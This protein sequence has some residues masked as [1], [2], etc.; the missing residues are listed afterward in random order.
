MRPEKLLTAYFS[1]TGTTERVARAIAEG[2]GYPSQTIDLSLP[3]QDTEVGL[4]TVLL[5]AVPVYGGRVPAVS[6]ER[7]A[8]LQ[9]HG[10]YAVA[11]AVYGNREFEDALLELKDAL[12]RGGFQVIA[13]AAFI[14]EHSI[15]RS[16]AAGRPD[17]ADLR[18][19]RQFGAQAAAKLAGGGSLSSVQVPGNTP[20]REFGGMPAHPKAGKACVKCGLCATRCPVGAIPPE[21]PEQ[22][23]PEKCITCMRCV[24]VCPEK[25]RALPAPVLLASKTMLSVKAAGYKKPQ[26][27]F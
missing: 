23:D 20:Y 6:L 3:Q 7:L 5:A 15:V 27:F 8:C 14:A 17:E 24:A 26:T 22:T 1:P 25:A 13:A 2:S 19:A 10:Q 11:V 4:D 16:I 21:H 18:A 9:G 12:V